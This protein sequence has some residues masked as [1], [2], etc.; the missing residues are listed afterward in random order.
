[1]EVLRDKKNKTGIYDSRFSLSKKITLVL[2]LNIG[3]I[4][5]KTNKTPAQALNLP[6]GT[7]TII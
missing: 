4:E 3:F 6:A 5:F 1:M 7:K 2:E